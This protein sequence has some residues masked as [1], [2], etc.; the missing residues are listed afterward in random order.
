VHHRIDAIKRVQNKE[1]YDDR[2]DIRT[3]LIDS[4]QRLTAFI[5]KHLPDKFQIID[6]QRIN[7]RDHL[8]R[9]IIGNLLV[10]QEYTNAFPA[11]LIIE[12]KQVFT[13]NWNKPHGTGTIDPANFSPFPKNPLIAKF[14]REMGWVD[15]LGSGVR[16]TYKYMAIYADGNKPVFSEDDIFKISIP[17]NDKV[18]RN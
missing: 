13:E 14:F 6:G 10:H 1:R 17:I 9:E 5:A 2:D 16:N 7:V 8:F 12:A 3:N 11:K 18:G 15:E 4:Y